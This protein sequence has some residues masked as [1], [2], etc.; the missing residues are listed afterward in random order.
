MKKPNRQPGWR[1]GGRNAPA[2]LQ[3][4]CAPDIK[5]R[6]REELDLLR[7][8][9]PF[10]EMS[11]THPLR[12]L[13]DCQGDAHALAEARFEFHHLADDLRVI[14]GVPGSRRLVQAMIS[15]AEGYA[16]YRYELRMAGTVGRFADQQLVSLGAKGRGADIEVKTRT[17]HLCGIA[18]YRAQSLTPALKESSGVLYSLAEKLGR[19]VV[20]NPIDAAIDYEIEFPSFPIGEAQQQSA[21]TTFRQVWA[22]FGNPKATHDG[23]TV[24]RVTGRPS[25]SAGNWEVRIKFLVPVPAG[26]KRRL[27]ER[28]GNKLVKEDGQWASSYSGYRLFCV[29]ESDWSLGAQQEEIKAMLSSSASHSF[30]MIVCTWPFFADNQDGGRIRL[31]QTKWLSREGAGVG[32]NLG[33]HTFGEN[34]ESYCKDH[35]VLIHDPKYAEE[36]WILRPGAPPDDVAGSRIRALTIQRTISRMPAPEGGRMPTA[37]ELVPLVRRAVPGLPG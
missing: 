18:C 2:W 19:A 30:G 8:T 14:R 34:F 26:E 1:L 3:A 28:I 11:G 17:G 29:E 16:D 31:E 9:F 4:P 6:V 32:L 5:K 33:M 23:V 13:W 10:H 24:S 7:D 20:A 36:E 35:V 12:K 15:D 22:D 37:E 27:C 25:F 21:V